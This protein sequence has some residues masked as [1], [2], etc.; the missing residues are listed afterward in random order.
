MDAFI[1][2]KIIFS[3]LASEF[4]IFFDSSLCIEL[5]KSVSNKDS[6]S[7]IIIAILSKPIPVSMFL[8]G[9]VP[10]TSKGLSCIDSINTRFHISTN[11]SSPPPIGP[12]SGPYFDPL[13]IKISEQGPQGPGIFICQKL[14]LSPYCILSSG[15]PISLSQ[16]S[17][18]SLSSL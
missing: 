16:I 17:K 13:S 10:T 8:L 3:Y 9:N 7:C 11:R 6:F 4:F 15:T 18:D 2:S 12:P 1:W 5:N 14:S